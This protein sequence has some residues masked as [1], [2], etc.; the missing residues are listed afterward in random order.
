[1]TLR[2]MVKAWTS[3]PPPSPEARVALPLRIN[4]KAPDWLEYETPGKSKA[5][6][7]AHLLVKRKSSV[8][9]ARERRIFWIAA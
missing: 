6:I 4:M 3:S 2:H 8:I 9:L 1:M 7:K 5:K